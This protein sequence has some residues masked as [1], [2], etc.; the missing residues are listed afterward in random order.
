MGK[1]KD[2]VR[3]Y[4]TD[5]E[6]EELSRLGV[7]CNI[8][9]AEEV[10]AVA[11]ALV[12]LFDEAPILVFRIKDIMHERVHRYDTPPNIPD[13]NIIKQNKNKITN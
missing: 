3:I 12:S 5:T 8:D 4:F 13:N 1:E 2:L 10:E 11:D 9:G 7:S 6:D